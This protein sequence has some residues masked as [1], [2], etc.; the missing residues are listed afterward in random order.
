M[1][2]L[3]YDYERE[4]PHEYPAAHMQVH[5]EAQY[6]SDLSAAV[7]ESRKE[8]RDF[9]FPVG[10][11]RFRPTVED[12]IDLVVSEGLVRYRTGWAQAVA[13]SRAAWEARQLRAA[14]RRTP[15]PAVEQLRRMGWTLTGPS[16]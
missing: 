13:D 4:P 9:H 16:E 14:V 11:R 6:L 12:A 2:I 10:G 8:L 5:G 1:P 3:H 15:W 7:C